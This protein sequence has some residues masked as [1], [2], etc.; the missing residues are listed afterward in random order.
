MADIDKVSIPLLRILYLKT[1]QLMLHLHS[2]REISCNEENELS[3]GK[4]HLKIN[5]RIFF[6]LF[7]SVGILF[8]SSLELI[9]DDITFGVSISTLRTLTV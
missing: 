8:L 7:I 2:D 9:D 3:K 1:V 4:F 6:S 5:E